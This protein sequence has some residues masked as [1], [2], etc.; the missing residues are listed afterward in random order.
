MTTIKKCE[1]CNKKA[2]HMIS[3]GWAKYLLDKDGEILTIGT[4][5]DIDEIHYYCDKHISRD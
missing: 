5:F 1:K 3:R 2:T 4:F